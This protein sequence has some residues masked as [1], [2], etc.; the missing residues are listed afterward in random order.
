[1]NERDVTKADYWGAKVSVA[2]VSTGYLSEP[3]CY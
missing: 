2:I 1:M 3:A